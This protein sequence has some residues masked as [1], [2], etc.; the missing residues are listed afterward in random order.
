MTCPEIVFNLTVQNGTVPLMHQLSKRLAQKSLVLCVPAGSAG[1]SNSSHTLALLA[2]AMSMWEGICLSLKSRFGQIP[3]GSNRPVFGTRLR[4]ILLHRDT[5]LYAYPA[6]IQNSCFLKPV[7]WEWY[8]L[9]RALVTL[10]AW[11]FF[12]LCSRVSK[13][14]CPR[15]HGNLNNYSIHLSTVFVEDN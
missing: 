14:R 9:P 6:G 13:A 5:V 12:V 1:S 15:A 2:P 11:V 10:I 4:G 3:R 7:H 8:H